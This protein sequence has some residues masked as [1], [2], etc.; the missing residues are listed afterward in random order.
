M[1]QNKPQKLELTWIGKDD[2]REAIEPRILIEDPKY[3]YGDA[4]SGNMLI[5]GD[6]LLA[7]KALEQQ[8]SNAIKCIYIDPPYNTGAAFELYDD[9]LEHSIWLNLMRSR[10]EIMKRLLSENGS[11]WISIDEKEGHYLKVLCDEI[12]GRKNF[13]I[14][15]II[16]RGAATGHKAINPTPVQVCDMMLTYAKDKEKWVYHPVYKERDFDKAYSSVIPN[17]DSPYQNWTFLSL[18]EFL[19]E[20]NITIEQAVKRYAKNIIRFAQPDYKAVGKEIRDLIDYSKSNPN[21]I[22]YFHRDDHPDIYLLNGNRILFYKD[23]FSID[24]EFIKNIIQFE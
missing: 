16:Q 3:S 17:I 20:K 6:N 2:D 5:H 11:I 4:E 23:K 21:E 13:I 24:K 22:C 19:N 7:L 1:T 15:T 9:H 18:K 12:F 14:Q 10:L 8:Y